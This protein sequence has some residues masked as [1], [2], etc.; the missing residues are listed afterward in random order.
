MDEELQTPEVAPDAKNTVHVS[1]KG[2][3][4]GKD[5]EMD[6]PSFDPDD[7]S[8]LDELVNQVKQLDQGY[9]DI[10]ASQKKEKKRAFNTRLDSINE[11]AAGKGALEAG[12]IGAL[13]TAL[14]GL[15]EAGAR[16]S[17][18]P[19]EEIDA[20]KVANPKMTMAGE[21]TG[22]FVPMGA[23]KS[24]LK[25]ATGIKEGALTGARIGGVFG[26]GAGTSNAIKGDEDYTDV[27][28]ILEG[29]SKGAAKGIALGT[30][31]GAGSAYLAGFNKNVLELAEDARKHLQEA[32][33]AGHAPS[34]GDAGKYEKDM[35]R[36]FELVSVDQAKKPIK[37][38]PQL[39]DKNQEELDKIAIDI[40]KQLTSSGKKGLFIPGTE[41]T[42]D[43]VR[44]ALF[45]FSF[46]KQLSSSEVQTLDQGIN[47]L[48]DLKGRSFTG[49][50]LDGL[51]NTILNHQKYASL[52]QETKVAMINLINSIPRDKGGRI[53]GAEVMAIGLRGLKPSK[54]IP[55]HDPGLNLQEDAIQSIVA[56]SDK[57]GNKKKTWTP[58][59]LE[60]RIQKINDEI[61]VVERKVP[62]A[63]KTNKQSDPDV[64]ALQN[65]QNVLRTK[66]DEV[67]SSGPNGEFRSQK[68]DLGTL[69]RLRRVAETARLSERQGKGVKKTEGISG[70]LQRIKRNA[71]GWVGNAAS[72]VKTDRD[73]SPSERVALGFEAWAKSKKQPTRAGELLRSNA[74]G[75]R[76]LEGLRRS[77]GEKLATEESILETR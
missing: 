50:G 68:Y 66:L 42:T 29:T 8:H 36:A 16:V 9:F 75:M 55:G 76:V 12:A 21:L 45:P 33:K 23:L 59:E 63:A 57:F 19:Q 30:P 47:A 10:D 7:S 13:D 3:F 35:E 52:P 72:I 38:L 20:L 67:M 69:M 27:P 70:G 1:L 43:Y 2:P 71:G 74:G 4:T 65:E 77:P 31:F 40:D 73:L 26:A 18:V 15:P 24:G 34:E 60:D 37:T 25:V 46:Q 56:Q 17:G 62:D 54:S 41:L 39:V 28:R 11:R 32:L 5:Y 6:V 48:M 53:P 58:W 61:A 51:A 14:A 22:A 64:A 49:P 44:N